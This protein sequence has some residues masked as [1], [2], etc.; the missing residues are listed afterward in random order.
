MF[1]ERATKKSPKNGT[2]WQNMGLIRYT[3]GRYAEAIPYFDRVLALT[4]KSTGFPEL[5]KGRCLLN[6]NRLPEACQWFQQASSAGNQEAG[7]LYNQ[8][9]GG[10]K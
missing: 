3:Q 9:C 8:N 6:L 4:V 2:L 7:Q 1:C 10:S 5:L